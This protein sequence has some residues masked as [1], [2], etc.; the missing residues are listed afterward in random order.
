[1]RVVACGDLGV[2]TPF[3]VIKPDSKWTGPNDSQRGQLLVTVQDV[4][5]EVFFDRQLSEGI[6]EGEVTWEG[7]NSDDRAHAWDKIKLE[8]LILG[9]VGDWHC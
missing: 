2:A 5:P 7:Q 1:M 4:T 9:S 6:L 8:V 3:V